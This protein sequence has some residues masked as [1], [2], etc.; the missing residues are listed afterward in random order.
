MYVAHNSGEEFEIARTTNDIIKP[1]EKKADRSGFQPM[2]ELKFSF[3]ALFLFLFL[4]YHTKVGTTTGNENFARYKIRSGSN[5]KQRTTAR[6][7]SFVT[8]RGGKEA[9]VIQL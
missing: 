7:L 1:K 3:R 4:Y 9:R 8:F 5:K 6:S 2:K